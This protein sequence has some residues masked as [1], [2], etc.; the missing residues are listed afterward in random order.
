MGLR[1]LVACLGIG[2]AFSLLLTAAVQAQT[3]REVAQKTFRSVVLLRLGDSEG[4]PIKLASGFFVKRGIVATNY[5][6]IEGAA[7]PRWSNLLPS[8]RR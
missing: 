8:C 3:A 6:V 5:H 2:L 1:L 7:T 4:R